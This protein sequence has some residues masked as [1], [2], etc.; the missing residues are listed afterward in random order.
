MKTDVSPLKPDE[1]RFISLREEEW[2][3][4]KMLT[5]IDVNDNGWMWFIKLRCNMINV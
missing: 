5:M 2:E 4:E 1:T 3:L